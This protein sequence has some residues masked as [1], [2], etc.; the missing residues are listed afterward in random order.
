MKRLYSGTFPM[1][2]CGS[3]TELVDSFGRALSVG[4][5]VVI[6]PVNLRDREIPAE[7]FMHPTYVVQYENENPFIMGLKSCRR[8]TNYY[9][10]GC[11]PFTSYFKASENKYDWK[12][13][14]YVSKEGY[15]WLVKKVKSYRETVD[16]ESWGSRY[17]TTVTTRQEG[18]E[19]CPESVLSPVSALTKERA[20]QAEEHK[21]DYAEKPAIRKLR[22]HLRRKKYV[23]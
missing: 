7:E 19:D 11:D 15:N 20:E 21:E 17:V 6:Y 12:E 13:D 14:V 10:D 8:V 4:D 16:G 9:L 3:P 22:F 23:C 1:G 2:I 18:Q 5:L